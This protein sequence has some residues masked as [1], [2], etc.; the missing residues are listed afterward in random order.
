MKAQGW[1]KLIH[2]SANDLSIGAMFIGDDAKV[3]QTVIRDT[4]K[5]I[6]N[7]PVYLKSGHKIKEY[8]NTRKI[9]F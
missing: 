1:K 5:I 8:L 4:L 6:Q 9:T 7:D 3:L 2:L